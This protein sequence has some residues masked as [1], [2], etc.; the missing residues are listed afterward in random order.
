MIILERLQYPLRKRLWDLRD[1]P[2][3]FPTT[4]D[5]VRWAY[6]ISS[7]LQYVH[8]YGVFQVDIGA[9]DMLDWG[10]NVKLSDFAGSSIDG[11]EPLILPSV[12]SEHPSCPSTTPS[13]Q[14]ELFALGSTLYEIETT[15]QPYYDQDDYVVESLFAQGTFPGT[16]GLVLGDV[17]S[18]CWTM[19]Y[20]NA[21]ETVD[22]IRHIQ[23][24]FDI[25]S[26]E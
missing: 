13:V 5:V 24:Q 23:E 21:R 7:A 17:I 19:K 12:H 18:K 3:K 9:H 11:S 2:A 8:S 20:A 1:T 4:T 14:S 6:Q 22:D 26:F 25:S 16:S 15:R 10:E